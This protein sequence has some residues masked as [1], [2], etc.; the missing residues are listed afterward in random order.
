MLY[1]GGVVFSK[2]A[3]ASLDLLDKDLS[4]GMGV[5]VLSLLNYY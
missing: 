4:W 2:E 1:G 5:D 3:L